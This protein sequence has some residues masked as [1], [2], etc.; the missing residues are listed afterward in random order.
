L[1]A[2]DVF[3]DFGLQNDRESVFSTAHCN[4]MSLDD[5][6]HIRSIESHVQDESVQS[7]ESEWLE[8]D[9]QFSPSTHEMK[10]DATIVSSEDVIDYS[11]NQASVNQ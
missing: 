5:S 11:I 10:F 6:G 8:V 3:V 9:D 1:I 7:G 4:D 2:I